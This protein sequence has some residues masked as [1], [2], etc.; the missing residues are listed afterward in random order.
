MGTMRAVVVDPENKGRLA[1]REVTLPSP[2]SSEALV[3]VFATSLNLGEVRAA[4]LRPQGSGWRPGWDLAGVVEQEAGDGSGPTVGTR[5]FGAVQAGSWAEFVAVPT[6]HLVAIP[7]GV[8]FAQ[9]ATLP[10]AGLTAFSGLERTGFLLN[11]KMLV[12]GASGG[13]GSFACQLAGLAGATVIALVRRVE[14]VACAQATRA[15]DV[16]VGEDIAVA[17]ALGP[18]DIV[19]DTLGGEA[20]ATALSLVSPDGICV[21]VGAAGDPAATVQSRQEAAKSGSFV[22]PDAARFLRPANDLAFLA[23]LV[24]AGQLRPHI[25]LEARWEGIAEV[26][27]RLLDRQIAGKAVLYL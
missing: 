11:K 27:Q 25:S 12:T 1:L 6:T 3:R 18:F 21:N 9:A 17:R 8:T 26:T 10:I 2:A 15:R 14:R 24:A 22:I 19:F 16:I 13:V 7:E 5:V 20:L 23:Q 4:V